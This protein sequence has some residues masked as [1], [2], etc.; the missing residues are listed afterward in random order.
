MVLCL[1]KFK[2][3]GTKIILKT[4]S[5]SHV[6]V[7]PKPAVLSP[8]HKGRVKLTFPLKAGRGIHFNLFDVRAGCGGEIGL[9]CNFCW[10]QHNLK[11]V[12]QI[13]VPKGYQIKEGQ[14]KPR[15]T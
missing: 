8:S 7:N 2:S 1:Y 10:I 15:L 14:P 3:I 6:H 5:E 4:T 13:L 11:K 12:L 9:V